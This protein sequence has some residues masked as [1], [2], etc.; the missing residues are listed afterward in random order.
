MDILNVDPFA[1]IVFAAGLTIIVAMGM[2]FSPQG[3]YNRM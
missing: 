3:S 1:V 2:F